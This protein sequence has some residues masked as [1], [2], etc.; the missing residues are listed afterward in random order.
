MVTPAEP[1][2]KTKMEDMGSLRGPRKPAAKKVTPTPDIIRQS[3]EKETGGNADQII[4]ALAA[5]V[6]KGSIK[7]LRIGDT[8]FS[9]IPKQAGTVEFHIF[10]VEDPETLVKRFKASREQ[11]EADGLQESRDLCRKPCIC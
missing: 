10:T 9:I 8:V 5:L 3:A 6:Q 1:V 7:L 11:F 4:N 2:L